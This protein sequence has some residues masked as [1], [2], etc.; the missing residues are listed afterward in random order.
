MNRFLLIL[1]S[2]NFSSF[3]W[4]FANGNTLNT[5]NKTVE[6]S[7]SEANPTG[8]LVYLRAFAPNGQYLKFQKSVYVYSPIQTP[9]KVSSPDYAGVTNPVTFT[10]LP[11]A[12]D[13]VT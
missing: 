2:S 13:R 3:T 7:F 10:V 11:N 1:F 6:F 5:T 9:L 12:G 4:E 8:H